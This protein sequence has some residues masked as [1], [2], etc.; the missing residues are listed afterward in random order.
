MNISTAWITLNRTCNLRCRWCYAKGTNFSSFDNMSDE[1]VYALLSFL[2]EIGVNCVH[3]TGGEPTLKSN[4]LQYI[5]FSSK[6]GLYSSLFTN[7]IMLSEKKYV[8]SLKF[9]GLQGVNLSLKGWSEESYIH[10]TGVN[11]FTSSFKA[12]ENLS[13]LN[14]NYLVSFVLSCDNI[15]AYLIA[16]SNALNHGASMVYLSFEQDFSVFDG[17][18]ESSGDVSASNLIQLVQKFEHSYDELNKITKGKFIVH[19]SLPFCIWRKDLIETMKQ[20]GQL[21]ANC[22]MR[23][24][25]GLVFSTNGSLILC[26]FMHQIPIGKFGVDF[27][28]INTFNQFWKSEKISSIYSTLSSLPSSICNTCEY[29]TEC[30]GG[31]IANWC[32][33]N[34][35][36][37]LAS[38]SSFRKIP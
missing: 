11:A 5:S 19:Q 33:F 7:G 13:E 31:C 28:D 22:Q 10:N 21:S 32:H 2:S 6:L 20:R 12:I 9:A 18:K 34:H 35:N 27:F 29:M 17:V 1:L 26:N 3:F 23:E 36:E 14:M 30:G 16:V 24:R 25:S 4:L 38:C 15:D 8:N 37:L